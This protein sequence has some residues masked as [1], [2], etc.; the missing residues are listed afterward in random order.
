[1]LAQAFTLPIAAA[2]PVYER[3]LSI[4]PTASRYWRQYVLHEQ[5][6]HEYARVEAL[7]SRCLLQCLSLP[8]FQSYIDYV[9]LVKAGA[10]DEHEAVEKAFDFVL[11]HMHLD[12][13]SPSVFLSYLSFLSTLPASSPIDETTKMHK[14]RR[15][16][17]RAVVVPGQ[18]VEELWREWDKFEHGVNRVLAVGLLGEWSARHLQAKQ[19][20]KERRR[21]SKHINA[22]L[23]AAPPTAASALLHASQLLHCKQLLQYL[24]SNPMHLS[25]ADQHAMLSFT[26]R[27]QLQTMQH[28]PALWLDYL[29]YLSS[30]SM[31]LAGA[32]EEEE[33]VW[34]EAVRQ[35]PYSLLMGCMFADWLEDRGRLADAKRQYDDMISRRRQRG[36]DDKDRE[37]EGSHEVKRRTARLDQPKAESDE[38]Q[39]TAEQPEEKKD[40]E[41]AIKQEARAAEEKAETQPSGSEGKPKKDAEAA[42]G[43]GGEAADSG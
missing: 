39:Q 29:S 6:A 9:R 40:S 7:F 15:V 30:V 8:L 27:Q 24:R 38:Q 2:R 43:R 19:V 25:P 42:G 36:R 3:F 32:R 17:Q 22:E 16:Y 28:Q 14:Q 11:Q 10:D 31:E 20:G 35:L 41:P 37:E 12:L 18:G 21:R 1:M 23:L 4:F 26:Y 33:S 34:K 13:H 5:A